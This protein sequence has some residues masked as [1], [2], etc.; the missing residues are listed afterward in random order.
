MDTFTKILV[1]V[2]TISLLIGVITFGKNVLYE[3]KDISVKNAEQLSD[4]STELTQSELERF[5]GTEWGGSDVI[6][7]I[8]KHLGDFG[9]SEEAPIYIQVNT[10]QSN[11]KYVNGGYIEEIQNFTSEKYIKPT[12]LFK[13]SVDKDKNNVILGIKF[14]QK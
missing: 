12:A 11:N 5:E 14:M 9:T 7:F 6:N 1:I 3:S 8:K 13:S 2:A 10:S 4:L